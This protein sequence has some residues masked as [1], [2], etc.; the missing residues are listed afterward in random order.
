MVTTEPEN[1]KKKIYLITD[2]KSND[3]LLNL[4]KEASF[5]S[6]VRIGTPNI[7]PELTESFLSLFDCFIYDLL[8][9]LFLLFQIHFQILP[10]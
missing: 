3:I 5:V 7:I 4:L 1:N 2:R 6:E 9:V 8:K 10:L